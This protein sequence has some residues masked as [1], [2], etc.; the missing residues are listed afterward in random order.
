MKKNFKRAAAAAMMTVLSGSMLAACSGTSK[1][2]TAATTMAETSSGGEATT[3]AEG[4]ALAGVSISM[5]NTK[6]EI[7]VALEELAKVFEADTGIK[8]DVIAAGAGESPYTR[9]TTM[10][11][12]NIAPTLALLDTTDVVALASEY[13]LD[14]T[15]SDWIA[16]TDGK[17]MELDG[18]VYSFPFCV[19]GRG[20]IYN[21][22]AIE[23]MLEREFDADSIKTLDDFRA[24]CEE[25]R[26]AGMETPVVLSKEDWSL[27]A[28]QFGYIYDT[29]DGTTEGSAKLIEDLKSGAVDLAQYQPFNDFVDTLD[30]LM[31]YNV[32]RDDPLGAL[33]DRDPI[34]LADGE[35]AFWANGNWAWPNLVEAGAMEDEGYGF[36]PFFLGND[37]SSVANSGMQASPSKQLMIDSVQATPEQIEAAKAFIDWMVYSENGQRGLVEDC[38]L[39]PACSNNPFD[40]IDPLGQDIA[41]KMKADRYYTSS[42]VAPGDHWSVVGAFVQKYV[43]GQSDRADLAANVNGY[44]TSQK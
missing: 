17:A 43:G 4:S 44:W 18:K 26:E 9:I 42:Y 24:I 36:L 33:Y 2:T 6:G 37:P 22:R 5:L 29:Y 34:Y 27:G 21:K 8:L 31:E 25:L 20:I 40:P 39:I 38:A 3:V 16:E 11:N 15:G 41:N 1:D 19:E 28:H 23:N 35:S 32:N 30:V 13:A 12:S 10:Y 14:L 7:Q